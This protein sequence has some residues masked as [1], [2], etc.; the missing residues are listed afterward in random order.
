MLKMMKKEE[1]K[2]MIQMIMN[3]EWKIIVGKSWRMRGEMWEK[4][5]R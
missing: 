2:R 5:K 1:N 3:E 4:E